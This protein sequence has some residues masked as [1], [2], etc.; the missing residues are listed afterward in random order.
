ML[1]EIQMEDAEIIV[2]WR[3]NPEVYRYFKNPHQI[4]LNEHLNWFLHTYPHNRNRIDWM[5][6]EKKSGNKIGIFGLLKEEE[7][8]EVNYIL[9]PEAQHQGYA[10]ESIYA[11]IVFARKEWSARYITA[12]I[13]EENIPSIQLVEKLGFYLQK[14]TGHFVVYELEV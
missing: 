9:A 13:H 4:T 6:I 10:K 2:K 8:T 3:S 12:E 7:N 11:L 1:R 14:K 5:C